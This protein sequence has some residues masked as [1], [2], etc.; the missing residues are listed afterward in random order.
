MQCVVWSVSIVYSIKCC[1]MWNYQSSWGQLVVESRESLQCAMCS[2]GAKVC[3][4]NV[5]LEVLWTVCVVF[6]NITNTIHSGP[7]ACKLYINW[8][9]R[10][11]SWKA[12]TWVCY[13]LTHLG[14]GKQKHGKLSTF[15]G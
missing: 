4:C 9:L 15:C 13:C 12:Y 7:A 5:K 10:H 1:V 11:S 6:G 8:L 2:V 3:S 14:K